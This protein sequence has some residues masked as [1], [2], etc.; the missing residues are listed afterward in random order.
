MLTDLTGRRFG[1][2]TVLG[3]AGKTKW[4][5]SKWL[6]RC[7]CGNERVVSGGHL[8]SGHTQSCGCYAREEASRRAIV[9]GITSGG[10]PRTFTI[11]NGMKAR[12]LNPKS[13]SFANYGGRGI[14]ICDEWLS[15]ENF[16]NWAV[17]NGYEDGLQIDRID[18]DGDYCPQNCRWVSRKYNNTNKRNTNLITICGKTQCA[19]DWIRELGISKATFYRHL[20]EDEDCGQRYFIAKFLGRDAA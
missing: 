18:N 2:L 4:G 14:G 10:K 16:H 19:T 13:V 20:H 1:R 9:H 7:D 6:C 8:K 12:C 15:F 5:D 3:Q 11:W 17:S